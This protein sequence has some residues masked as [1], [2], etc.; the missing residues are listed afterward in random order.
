MIKNSLKREI[1]EIDR[2]F[3]N[4]R[5]LFNSARVSKAAVVEIL[6]EWLPGFDH[7]EK[8]KGLDSKM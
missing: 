2:I 7:I 1:T 4:L 6:K 5:E 8:E 3:N